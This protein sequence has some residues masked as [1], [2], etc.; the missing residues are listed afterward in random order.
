M[1]CSTSVHKRRYYHVF[2]EVLI[3]GIL[4]CG[5]S[6]ND[7]SNNYLHPEEDE[8][9]SVFATQSN[10]ISAGTSQRALLQFYVVLISYTQ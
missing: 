9:P 6:S 10:Q 5:T 2:F 7:V 8:V 3:I 1:S 4:N